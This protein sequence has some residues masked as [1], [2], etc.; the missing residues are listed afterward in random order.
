MFIAVWTLYASDRL[1]DTEDLELRHRFHQKHRDAFVTGIAAA[2]LALAFLL[3][4][5]PLQSIHLYLI[6]GG[7]VDCLSQQDL[8]TLVSHVAPSLAPGGLWLFSDFSVPPG[9]FA[10][11][12][13][14]F[15]RGLYL[16]FRIITG[17]RTTVLPDHAALLTRAGL[18]QIAGHHRLG[19]LLTT[20]LWQAVGYRRTVP[21]PLGVPASH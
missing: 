14:I 5:I 19:G 7:L 12:A 1:L 6:L 8:D 4:H 10:I 3:S 21:T 2:F 11:P 17:L 18:S 13:R 9:F 15:I 20:E 16:A